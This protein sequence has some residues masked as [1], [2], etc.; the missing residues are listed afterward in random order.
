MKRERLEKEQASLQ[1]EWNLRHDRLTQLRKDLVLQTIATTKFPLE[2][3][4]Q[5][6]L[7][8]IGQLE[9]RLDEIEESL[10]PLNS[11]NLQISPQPISLSQPQHL[12]DTVSLESENGLDYSNLRDFLKLG[13]WIAADNE[14]AR[15]MLEAVNRELNGTRSDHRPLDVEEIQKFPCQ[16]LQTIDR[17]WLI[18]SQEH[19]GFSV[20]RKIWEECGSPGSELCWYTK[21]DPGQ[22]WENFGERIGW[23]H[24]F[25]YNN[26]EV[27]DWLEHMKVGTLPTPDGKCISPLGQLPYEV[28]VQTFYNYPQNG[29]GCVLQGTN[30]GSGQEFSTLMQRLIN[31]C[32][33]HWCTTPIK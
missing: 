31:C 4:I 17:L 9:K 6:E 13:N 22:V 27:F 26:H 15:V 5:A 11:S 3:E 30:M 25:K 12:I 28:F 16:D 18:A 2:K 20:Q 7:E 10:E 14:T 29:I 21:K 33:S 23:G 19:F 1:Q 8:I 32:N 24:K